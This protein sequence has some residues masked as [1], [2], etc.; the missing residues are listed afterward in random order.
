MSEIKQGDKVRQGK[1]EYRVLAVHKD[2][3]HGW[4][5]STQQ[6]VPPFTG[7]LKAY[8]KVKPF[9]EEGKTYKRLAR[10][11]VPAQ[12]ENVRE[13][14]TVDAVRTDSDGRKVA[15]GCLTYSDAQGRALG[16][17]QWTTMS[18]HAFDHEGWRET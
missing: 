10:W 12:K 1:H 2:G 7:I 11:S 4:L 5:Q 6:S 17:H 3:V 16:D 13:R 15:F 8:D 18:H 14:F 9:F